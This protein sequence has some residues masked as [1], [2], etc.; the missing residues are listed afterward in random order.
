MKTTLRK[1][2]FLGFLLGGLS[3]ALFWWLGRSGP[4]AT[5]RGRAG[6]VRPT[7]VEVMP[8]ERGA[9][10]LRR[11]FSGALEPRAE[12]VVA[13]KVAGRVERLSV[14]IAD[15]VQRGQLVGELDNDEYL[16]AVAQARADLAVTRDLLDQAATLED[17]R[18]RLL[19]LYGD[20]GSENLG[21]LLANA[22]TL[23]DLAGRDEVLNGR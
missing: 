23:A 11:T 20:M 21:E 22:L 8:I 5:P 15:L 12:L 18:D 1:L 3:A 2:L 6:G 13:P 16:Q 9:I 14:A 10:E 7:P 19:D 4:E 17:F